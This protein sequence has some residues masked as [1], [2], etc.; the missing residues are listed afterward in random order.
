MKDE[1]FRDFVL[2]QLRE[3][4]GLECCAMFGGFGLYADGRFFGIF[5]RGRLYFK[6]SDATREA[7][8]ARGMKRFA[9]R[10]KATLS[11]YLEVPADVIEDTAQ[12]ETWARD[13]VEAAGK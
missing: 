3:L 8:L 5:H 9:P 2:D 6:T 1:S 10:G 13:A 11:A 7:Y 12:L 4:R